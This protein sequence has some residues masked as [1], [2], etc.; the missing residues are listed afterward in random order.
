MH[1]GTKH[2]LFPLLIILLVSACGT[3]PNEQ[4]ETEKKTISNEPIVDTPVESNKS[5]YTIN[6]Q[7]SEKNSIKVTTTDHPENTKIE[8]IDTEI[9]YSSLVSSDET[10]S[11]TEDLK[12]VN[13]FDSK[14]ISNKQ[15]EPRTT[16]QHETLIS[17]VTENQYVPAIEPEENDPKPQPAVLITTKVLVLKKVNQKVQQLIKK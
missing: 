6:D 10:S 8:H 14:E 4:Y 12:V 13:S 16:E 7:I 2:F 15:I 9:Y 3:V 11:M 1:I 5:S 17:F